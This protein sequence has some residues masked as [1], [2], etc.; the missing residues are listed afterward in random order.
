MKKKCGDQSININQITI[1]STQLTNCVCKIYNNKK[2]D[3]TGT[4]FI[5]KIPFPDQYNYLHVLITNHH[6][7]DEDNL[8][9][10]EIIKITFN[11]DKIKKEIK[12]NENRMFITKEDIDITIIEIYQE[13]CLNMY[14]E[15]D[16]NVFNDNFIEIYK[17]AN[18]YV[19]QYPLGKQ[20]SYSSGKLIGNKNKNIQHSCSTELGSS[21]SPILNLLTYKVIG[22]HKRYNGKLDNKMIHLK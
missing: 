9:T 7:L 16:P 13:E 8:I 6:I 2:K 22:V 14:L 20:P 12:I 5:C 21:G 18:I 17:N 1:I 15:I 11:D 10:N 4:G 19:L 3:I